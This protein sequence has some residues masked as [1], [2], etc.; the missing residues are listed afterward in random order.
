MNTKESQKC[1]MED[2]NFLK[3]NIHQNTPVDE[4]RRH[5][6]KSGLALSGVLLTLASRPSLGADVCKTPSGFMSAN[7]SFHGTPITCAGLSPGYW[8]NHPEAWPSPYQADTAAV[9]KKGKTAAIPATLGTMFNNV[10]LGF[11]GGNFAGKSM[12][13]VIWLGGQGDPYQLGMHC[14]SALLNAKSGR[15]PIL[16]EAQVRNM[17]NEYASK[18]YFEPTAG[19]HWSPAEIVTYL[20]HTM[21]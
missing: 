9:P 19:V 17:F 15:T 11:R 13:G 7:L 8:G 16:T 2:H 10:S 21:S 4:S 3:E 20:K 5:A 18:G 1:G 14:V 6:T 12:M